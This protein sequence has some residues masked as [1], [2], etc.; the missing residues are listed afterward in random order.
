MHEHEL[1]LTAFFNNNLAGLAN[2]FLALFNLKAEHPERPWENWIVM[3]I[4]IF[5][6]IVVLVAIL[7]SSFSVEKPGKLQHLFE[8]LF[9]FLK[10][11]ADEVG[12]QHSER[13][14]PYFGTVFTF[15][16]FMNLL[17]IIPTFESPTM[18]AN[19]T[20][21][22]AICTFLY[23]NYMGLRVQG[24]GYLKHFLGPVWWLIPLMIPIEVMGLFAKPLS[25]TIRL[26]ANMFAGEQVTVQFIKLTY[27][28]I[29]VIFMALHVFVSFLQAY[30][31]TLL[32]MIYI[33]GA[34]THEEH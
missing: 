33:S 2:S 31:F 15:I 8:V 30:I 9:A 20:A 34:T 27:F 32:S 19:V 11:T 26:F 13:Y 24:G 14:V 6:I 17:G 1:W 7:R 18:S 3:E 21:G 22:L 10:N 4:L 28:I 29:P 25:L 12:I 23:F 5:A 16:L